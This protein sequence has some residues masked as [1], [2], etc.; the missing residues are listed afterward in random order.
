MGRHLRALRAPSARVSLHKPPTPP[1]LPAQPCRRKIE[2]DFH[3]GVFRNH[4]DNASPEE[5]RRLD[6]DQSLSCG[7]I[8][9]RPAQLLC[10]HMLST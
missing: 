10:G 9:P 2:F 7:E 3:R 5:R 6:A 8:T 4:Y 1:G